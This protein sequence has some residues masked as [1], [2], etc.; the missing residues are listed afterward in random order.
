MDAGWHEW[1]VGVHT[2][3]GALGGR[4]MVCVNRTGFQG[5][6]TGRTA[7]GAGGLEERR[8]LEGVCSD[9]LV[10]GPNGVGSRRR[11]TGNGRLNLRYVRGAATPTGG[12]QGLPGAPP[13][14]PVY[15]AHR[16]L[17]QICSARVNWRPPPGAVISS[18]WIRNTPYDIDSA[19]RLT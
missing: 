3:L 6:D 9:P 12:G 5:N 19:T 13:V 14:G 8:L 17:H 15:S 1:L 2:S 16:S 7:R 10:R 11:Q 4:G 18:R